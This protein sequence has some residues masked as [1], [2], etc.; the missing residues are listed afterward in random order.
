MLFDILQ[1][2]RPNV[3]ARNIVYKCAR[4]TDRG[5]PQLIDNLVGVD[6]MFETFQLPVVKLRKDSP[7][8]KMGFKQIPAEKIGL[9]L[10]EKKR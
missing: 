4:F 5:K 9:I 7:A 1:D 10:S 6:P 8:F 2:T 3:L